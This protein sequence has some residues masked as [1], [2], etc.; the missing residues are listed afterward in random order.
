M[1]RYA[2]VSRSPAAMRSEAV[3]RVHMLKSHVEELLGFVRG[4]F[5]V[6]LLFVVVLLFRSS[7]SF[8]VC[9]CSRLVLL[10]RVVVGAG[11]WCLLLLLMLPLLCLSFSLLCGGSL[12]CGV[13][14]FFFVGLVLLHSDCKL[15]INEWPGITCSYC[16]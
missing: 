15:C 12:L 10:L 5:G 3:S 2:A 1:L 7:S 13:G 6:V 8:V 14:V 4:F 11:R 16:R 9:C